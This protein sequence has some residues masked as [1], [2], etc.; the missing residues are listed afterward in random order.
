MLHHCNHV[1]SDSQCCRKFDASLTYLPSKLDQGRWTFGFSPMSQY[2]TKMNKLVLG[3]ER[4]ICKFRV[5]CNFE[6][7]CMFGSSLRKY[8]ASGSV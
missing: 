8:S 4:V 7:M 6:I 3:L 1:T 2:C 5:L